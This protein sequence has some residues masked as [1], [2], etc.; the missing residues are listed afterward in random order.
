ME[1]IQYPREILAENEI[2]MFCTGLHLAPRVE[3]IKQSTGQRDRLHEAS[4]S[5]AAVE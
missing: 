4:K 1:T 5:R 3:R 2:M